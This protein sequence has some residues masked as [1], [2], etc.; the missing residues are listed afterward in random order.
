MTFFMLPDG[1]AGERRIFPRS[2]KARARVEA[3]PETVVAPA[4]DTASATDARA[5]LP[6]VAGEWTPAPR[7]LEVPPATTGLYNPFAEIS[8][9]A[10][11]SRTESGTAWSG[12]SAARVVSLPGEQPDFYSTKVELA[13][14][15]RDG[16]PVTMSRDTSFSDSDG[17]NGGGLVRSQP[18]RDSADA[19]GRTRIA[20]RTRRGAGDDETA[21]AAA[22]DGTPRIER[23]ILPRTRRGRDATRSRDQADSRG[24]DD[25]IAREWD[26][27]RERADSP[28]RERENKLARDR[29]DSLAREREDSLAR[30]RED[31]PAREWTDDRSPAAEVVSG[32][33][34]YPDADR[35][36]ATAGSRGNVAVSLAAA[37][38]LSASGGESRVD[39]DLGEA[40]HYRADEA[41]S[42]DAG[43]LKRDG[44]RD[45][46]EAGSVSSAL[47]IDN[48]SR[49]GLNRQEMPVP[50]G[51][52]DDTSIRSERGRGI[53]PSDRNDHGGNQEDKY[54]DLSTIAPAPKDSGNDSV[55][56]SPPAKREVQSV[57]VMP[58]SPARGAAIAERPQTVSPDASLLSPIPLNVG[59]SWPSAPAPER[60]RSVRSDQTVQSFRSG[61]YGEIGQSGQSGQSGQ[62]GEGGSRTGYGEES[63]YSSFRSITDARRRAPEP[64]P[65]PLPP[66]VATGYEALGDPWRQPPAAPPPPAE[67]ERYRQRLENRLLERYNNLPEYSGKVS[68]VTVVLSR[69]LETSMDGSM[70]RAEFDQLV[71]D[72]WGKRIAEL[73]Q[74]Y[75]AVTFASGGVQQMRSDPSIRIGLDMEKTYSERAP[76]T[77]DP[78]GSGPLGTDSAPVSDAFG[79]VPTTPMPTWW[80]PQGEE[81]Y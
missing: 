46:S 72:P 34:E 58:N 62:F 37:S 6:E 12:G 27:R 11:A 3:S 52:E 32:R 24:R 66:A 79:A 60:E 75:F 41:A 33:S 78:F 15:S 43:L 76:L 54:L 50:S 48:E 67:V 8:A 65:P 9:M 45:E 35:R 38:V 77:A 18:A 73:E 80:R 16:R 22:V 7:R 39:N 70:I 1:S 13:P 71:Y 63:G 17:V 56:G 19:A 21:S 2:R 81:R 74:E 20:S 49:S 69:P 31:S 40:L 14:N 51:R 5:G 36:S 29:E 44:G 23:T 64:E 68:K 28:A 10:P 26:S 55:P 61:Q 4:A 30:E 25:S 53:I 42:I 47:R 59:G 57:P